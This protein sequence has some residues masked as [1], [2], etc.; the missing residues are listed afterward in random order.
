[1]IKNFK[2]FSQSVLDTERES[3]EYDLLCRKII[4]NEKDIKIDIPF[5]TIM[6]IIEFNVPNAK[7][8]IGI[9]EGKEYIEYECS[10][11]GKIKLYEIVP[12]AEKTYFEVNG[13]VYIEDNVP[14]AR[15]FYLKLK[16]VIKNG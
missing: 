13:R 15:D 1:M 12:L 9:E 5:S 10:R 6:Q 7:I 2:E 8:T 3:M 14:V 11:I 16:E 4:R